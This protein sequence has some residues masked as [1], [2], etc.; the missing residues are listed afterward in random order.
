[1]LRRSPVRAPAAR[2]F[3]KTSHLLPSPCTSHGSALTSSTP[4][5]R[6]SLRH[7]PHSMEISNRS[8]FVMSH[9]SPPP[10]L[11]YPHHHAPSSSASSSSP[12]TA[13][14]HFTQEATP[15]SDVSSD[16]FTAES[17]EEDEVGRLTPFSPNEAFS[18]DADDDDD[19]EQDEEVSTP[20]TDELY[21][22]LGSQSLLQEDD[23]E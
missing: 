1:M 12:Y 22:M 8:S 11:L 16:T 3:S 5:S 21:A 15:K 18:D 17:E 19:D 4:S 13:S 9:V 2:L 20:S 7:T 6:G 10:P 14:R 23:E